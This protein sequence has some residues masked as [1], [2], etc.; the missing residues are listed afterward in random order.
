MATRQFSPD[1]PELRL[2]AQIAGVAPARMAAAFSDPAHFAEHMTIDEINRFKE[3]CDR[4]FDV[5]TEM[6][7][8]FHVYLRSKGVT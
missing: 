2:L 1:L 3:G 4:L 7:E 6:T 5:Q 8:A